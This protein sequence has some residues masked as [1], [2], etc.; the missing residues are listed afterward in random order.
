MSALPPK[1]EMRAPIASRAQALHEAQES[2]H[3]M[4]LRCPMNPAKVLVGSP[5]HFGFFGKLALPPNR[6][7]IFCAEATSG[8][9]IHNFSGA[10]IT[11]WRKLI[12]GDSDWNLP[13]TR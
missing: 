3:L 11:W 7:R 6:I 12:F 13:S 9:C 1:A 5:V 8:R 10:A 4:R 2:D